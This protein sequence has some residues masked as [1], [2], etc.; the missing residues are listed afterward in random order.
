MWTMTDS[1]INIK[2]IG[3]E[4]N[5]SQRNKF[6]MSCAY[7]FLHGDI[8][9]D[10]FRSRDLTTESHDIRVPLVRLEFLCSDCYDWVQESYRFCACG[11]SVPELIQSAYQVRV[12]P[13]YV[14]L[15]AWDV[16]CEGQVQNWLLANLQIPELAAL[17]QGYRNEVCRAKNLEEFF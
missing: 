12:S 7:N 2:A 5:I 15:R 13:V 11:N 9:T 17:V 6:W 8:M 10:I 4:R 16:V 14:L 1:G 3:K